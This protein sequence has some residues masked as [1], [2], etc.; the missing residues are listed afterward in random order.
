M[1]LVTHTPSLG[2]ARA[3]YY[4]PN[5]TYS[6]EEWAQL[7]DQSQEIV[8][9]LRTSGMRRY[10]VAED[11]TPIELAWKAVERCC[12]GIDGKS[13][14]VLIVVST[15]GCSRPPVPL[16]IHDELRRRLGMDASSLCF[17]FVDMHCA[18]LMGAIQL[19]HK[20]FTCDPKRRRAI[21]VAVD[22]MYEE[23]ARNIGHHAIQSDGASALLL[24]RDT[25]LN[26]CEAVAIHIEPKYAEGFLK[27]SDMQRR[28]IDSYHII[29]YGVITS[30]LEKIGWKFGEVDTFLFPNFNL[31][32]YAALLKATGIDQGRIF[33]AT[34]NVGCHGH[35]NCSDFVVNLKDW[36]DC[37]ESGERKILAYATG[38]TGFFSAIALTV[39]AGATDLKNIDGGAMI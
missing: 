33:D 31:A 17:S 13:I 11:D 39:T 3:A 30:I 14:N 38:T 26:R 35:S 22:K 36:L 7:S 10:H 6:V 16:M 15:L 29:A 12:E 23:W 32:P 37:R 19:V 2:I 27:P 24:E 18:S 5:T 25:S 20:L 34:D 21:V 9:G 8:E 4:F 28:F 1:T